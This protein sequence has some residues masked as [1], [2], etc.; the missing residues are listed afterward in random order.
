MLPNSRVK[1]CVWKGSQGS[2]NPNSPPSVS[3]HAHLKRISRRCKTRAKAFRLYNRCD[4]TQQVRRY[5]TGLC[6]LDRRIEV[7]DEC[8]FVLGVVVEEFVGAC[9]HDHETEAA[10]ANTFLFA[11]TGVLKRIGTFIGYR[12]MRNLLKAKSRARICD[13]VHQHTRGA[14][15]RNANSPGGIKSAAPFHRIH[16][17]FMEAF[18]E[19]VAQRFGQV[20]LQV[21]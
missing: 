20:G 1:S 4:G 9:A 18:R 2:C 11:Y 10:W 8:D 12:G 21:M 17:Q 16:E 3:T 19:L 14:H 5:G 6:W 13:S 15:A 7:L